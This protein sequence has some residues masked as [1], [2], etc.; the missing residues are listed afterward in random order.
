MLTA[1]EIKL[2]QAELSQ[3][4]ESVIND[5]I[6]KV[7][8]LILDAIKT[9]GRTSVWVD[10]SDLSFRARDQLQDCGYY[11]TETDDYKVL[12][13]WDIGLK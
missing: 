3:T 8:A 9:P 5:Q 7:E 12:V 6:D 11:V 2:K 4:N 13:S 10:G 1:L